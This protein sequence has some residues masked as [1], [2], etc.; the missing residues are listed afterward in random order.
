MAEG[1]KGAIL[2]RCD[3][4]IGGVAIK[5][6]FHTTDNYASIQRKRGVAREADWLSPASALELELD[7]PWRKAR[8]A[9]KARVAVVGCQGVEP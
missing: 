3:A 6:L 2:E 1:R 8:T 4:I 9:G 7:V 5:I